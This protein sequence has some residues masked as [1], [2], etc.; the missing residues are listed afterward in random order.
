MRSSWNHNGR[1]F[2]VEITPPS[3]DGSTR[4]RVNERSFQF[5]NLRVEDGFLLLEQLLDDGSGTRVL[6]LPFARSRGHVLT[7]IE[8]LSF[9]MTPAEEAA[10]NSGNAQ[11]F[12]GEIHAPMPGK[13]LDVLVEVGQEVSEDQPLLILE[14]M[15]MEQTLKASSAARVTAVHVAADQMVSPG[16]LLVQLEKL[17]TAD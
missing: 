11:G 15:K 5:C 12:V 10:A 8:A 16:D 3:S 6:R 13:V 14:A 1:E 7:M 4:V 2:E 9:E 17:E